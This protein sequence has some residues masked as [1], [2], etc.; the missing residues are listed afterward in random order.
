MVKIKRFTGSRQ[1]S[2]LNLPQIDIVDSE[3]R[4]QQKKPGK[5]LSNY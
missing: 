5:I 1:L 4:Y 2:I 3:S